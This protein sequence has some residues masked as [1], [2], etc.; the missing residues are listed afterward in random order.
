GAAL[1]YRRR[2]SR[3]IS[4]AAGVC[5]GA[6][7]TLRRRCGGNDQCAQHWRQARGVAGADFSPPQR[8]PADV[9]GWPRFGW[10]AAIA[11]SLLRAEF[12]LPKNQRRAIG[13]GVA[14]ACLSNAF[15]SPSVGFMKNTSMVQP[16]GA[17]GAITGISAPCAAGFGAKGIAGVLGRLHSCSDGPRPLPSRLAQARRSRQRGFGLGHEPAHD[18]ADRKD[19]IDAPDGL[20]RGEQTLVLTARLGRRDDLTPQAIALAARLLAL[21][22]PLV[23]ECRMERTQHGPK[24]RRAGQR[25]D[26]VENID[27]DRILRLRRR[28]G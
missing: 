13:A 2:R 22:A 3:Q 4:H 14:Q 28:Y 24:P 5:F 25:A 18:L 11:A 16:L 6:L 9:P 27:L 21:G 10:L 17:F 7:E 1:R 12:L 20:S 8:L 15:F 26:V 23:E 19:F